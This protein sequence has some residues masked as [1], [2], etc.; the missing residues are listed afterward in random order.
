MLAAS[1]KIGVLVGVLGMA[2]AAEPPV[3]SPSQPVVAV[4]PV[5]P[6]PVPTPTPEPAAEPAPPAEPT[7]EPAAVPEPAPAPAPARPP[8]LDAATVSAVTA[9]IV[10][11]P[12]RK[13]W[14]PCGVKHSVGALEVE[15][16]DV[17]EPAPRMIL[18]VSC[19]VGSRRPALVV[20]ATLVFTL[21]ARKQTWP[22]VRGLPADL[23]RRYV[24]AYADQAAGGTL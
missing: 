22:G 14:V 3:A 20:G 12:N 6:V 11:I 9:K 13:D 1:G 24:S 17:G 19:P 7:P 8:V 5:A 2:C 23:P 4:E 18:L 15:V 16:Q 10:A 21:H